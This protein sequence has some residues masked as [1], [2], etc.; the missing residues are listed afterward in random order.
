MGIT[1]VKSAAV[2]A[3]P[4]EI[5]Y[6]I[7]ESIPNEWTTEFNVI[8]DNLLAI[9]PAKKNVFDKLNV[10]AWNAK[11]EDPFAG[12]S[13]GA[14]VGGPPSDKIM[15]LEIPDN[16]FLFQDIQRGDSLVSGFEMF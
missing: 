14:Y 3:A 1:N 11:V 6:N 9:I 4:I 10:Y 15:V 8:M 13:G 5:K 16:E 7:H 12:V 2:S